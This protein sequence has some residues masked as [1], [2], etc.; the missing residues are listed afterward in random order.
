MVSP[1]GPK[2]FL[3]RC[4]V[5]KITYSTSGKY[6]CV[7][8]T[9]PEVKHVIEVKCKLVHGIRCCIGPPARCILEGLAVYYDQ[10]DL[11]FVI[12]DVFI[13]FFFGSCMFECV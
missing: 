5:E 3:L 7:F 11:I 2:P 6:E 13:N 1:N 4:S 8:K 10:V 9:E 12:L